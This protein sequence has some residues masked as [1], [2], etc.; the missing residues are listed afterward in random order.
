MKP[1]QL[2][3]VADGAPAE[4]PVGA[5]PGPLAVFAVEASSA[6]GVDPAMIAG[7]GLAAMAA[8][9]GNRRRI[10]VKPGSW[11]EPACLW[12]AV[13]QP[14]G[15]LK[16]PA[17]GLVLEHLHKREVSEIAA[18]EREVKQWEAEDK[19]ERG[20][21]PEPP[22]R[23]VVSDVTSEALLAIHGRSPMGLLMHRD[24]LAGWLRSFN[25]YKSGGGDAQ[26]WAEMHQ[27]QPVL[28]DRKTS[29][30][31]SVPRACVSVVGGLQPGILGVVLAGE[32]LDDGI[33]SRILFVHPP[34]TEKVWT[35]ERL[36][37]EVKKGWHDLLDSLKALMPS[38]D[39]SPIDLP[40]TKDAKARWVECYNSRAERMQAEEEGPFRSAMSK[41]EAATAR[42]ALIV[43]LGEKPGSKKVGAEAM[44]AGIDLSLWFESQA[45]T[46]YHGLKVTK[47]DRERH[48][49]Y[50]WIADRPGGRATRRQVQREG[51][52]KFRKKGDTQ[53]W[54]DDLVEAEMLERKPKRGSRVEVYEVL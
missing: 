40:M 31:I 23:L 36:S 39:G 38:P 33:A 28:V 5:L 27:A 8:A 48:E 32:H 50:Q 54:L 52:K 12:V 43:Q 2:S 41:L 15:G 46:I 14:S 17:I 29:G 37:Q 34:P 7:P 35:D 53:K 49:L 20:E 45:W 24:E 26:T 4:F 3:Q 9:I 51:P 21:K 13:V 18:W 19:D 1:S 25:A 10:N 42:L 47:L 44:Q 6:L 11:Y 16:T 22:P 30:T